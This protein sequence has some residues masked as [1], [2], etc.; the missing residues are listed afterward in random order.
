MHSGILRRVR[1]CRWL[2]C[3]SAWMLAVS[4]SWSQSTPAG[5]KTIAV[6]VVLEEALRSMP[7]SER[8]PARHALVIGCG[9]FKDGRIPALPACRNDAEKLYE[10]LVDPRIGLFPKEHVRL[11]LDEEAT[12]SSVKEALVELSRRAGVSDLV[13]VFF[14]GHGATDDRGRAYWVMHE[15]EQDSLRATALPEG[16]VTEL[17]EEVRTTRLVTLVDACYSAATATLSQSKSLLDLSKIYPEFKGDGRVMIASSKGDQKSQ[18]IKEGEGAGYSAFAWHVIKGLEGGASGED[19]IVTV[20]ELWAYVRDRTEETSRRVGGHQEPQLKGQMGS[21]FLLAVNADRLVELSKERARSREEAGRRVSALAEHWKRGEITALQ[22]EEG[23]AL[24]EHA[25]GT[26]DEVRER[27]RE[28]YAELADREIKPKWLALALSEHPLESASDREARLLRERI[29]ELMSKARA[30]DSRE[31]GREALSAL[32]EVLR[33]D[34]AH[35]EAKSLRQRIARYYE[36]AVPAGFTVVSEQ[37]D[38]S[39]VTDASARDRLSATGLPWKIRHER[40]GI[41]MLLC[42]PGEFMMGSAAGE[43]DREAD[44]R[45]HRRTIRRPFYLSETEV[46]QGQ[47][48]AVMGSNPSSFEGDSNPVESVSWNDCQEFMGRAGDGLRLPSEAEWEYACRAGTTTA[49]SFGDD[50]GRLGEHAWFDGR[51]RDSRKPVATRRPN[52]WGLYDMHGNVWEWCEDGYAEYP[53][54]GTEESAGP[55]TYRVLRGG[56]W[57]SYSRRCRAAT[58]GYDVPGYRGNYSGFRVARTP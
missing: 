1:G 30:N 42:P 50:A 22:L 17:L 46:T 14:S 36:P 44:E 24:L 33:L 23:R 45:P 40:S 18:V 29:V 2:A 32:D 51:L 11:L 38:P 55:A 3:A 21:K 27:R 20:D 39:V 34:P 54:S 8:P 5:S 49:Y 48:Q 53:V 4:G 37:P 57:G 25:P 28:V 19:G 52:A 56:S 35:A 15:T 47:W 58:R 7:S 13:V 26:L 6:E 10:V 41:V 31:Q 16:D 43:A 12:Q 9:A